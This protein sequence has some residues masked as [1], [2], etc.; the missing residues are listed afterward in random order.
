M[1]PLID[2]LLMLLCHYYYYYWLYYA[3]TLFRL[4][5]FI[6]DYLM[7][8]LRHYRLFAATL[9]F[10]CWYAIIW[11]CW[12]LVSDI[13][14]RHLFSILFTRWLFSPAPAF[15]AFAF[16]IHIHMLSACHRY[17]IFFFSR[18]LRFEIF[19]SDLYFT[20]FTFFIYTHYCHFITLSYCRCAIWYHF[21]PPFLISLLIDLIIIDWL[22]YAYLFLS[23][24]T[25]LF[26][27]LI[28]LMMPLLFSLY[29][30]ID[31]DVRWYCWYFL[32]FIFDY[33]R[34]FSDDFLFHAILLF[35]I[36]F[37]HYFAI[38]FTHIS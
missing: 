5:L 25:C 23:F 27:P 36:F 7:P 32:R 31:Y 10:W 14:L 13:D 24:I 38:T 35:A 20:T 34:L 17:Y 16:A 11:C 18:R 21:E 12:V 15:I 1:P 37:F 8:W 26:S 33:F 3:I 4:L 29:L 28:L 2:Y 6:I 22:R 19:F 9:F 30:F